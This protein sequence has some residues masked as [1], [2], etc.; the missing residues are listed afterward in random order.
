MVRAECRTGPPA[1][2]AAR[3][4]REGCPDL[5][6]LASQPT[7][8]SLQKPLTGGGTLCPS[9]QRTDLSARP[10]TGDH[11]S[12]ELKES[13]TRIPSYPNNITIEDLR[14]KISEQI[15]YLCI[16]P[17]GKLRF[18]EQPMESY[19]FSYVSGRGGEPTQNTCDRIPDKQTSR[20][21]PLVD[22]NLST[23]VERL[24]S[25]QEFQLVQG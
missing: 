16:I 1:V 8:S 10:F 4:Y 15:I 17:L 24:I 21:S 12:L 19:T 5:Q 23:F 11:K 20:L 9:Y 18:T 3:R 2:E 13:N 25:K 6:G 7:V 14:S 22:K